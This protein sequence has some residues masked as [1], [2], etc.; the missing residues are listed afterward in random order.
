MAIYGYVTPAAERAASLRV[1]ALAAL[2][3]VANWSQIWGNHS[4]FAQF[5]PPSPLRHVWSHAVEEQWYLFWPPVLLGLLT[6]FRRRL[7]PVLAVVVVLMLGSALWMSHLVRAFADPSRAYYGTDTRAQ[8]LLAGAAL[9]LVL[10]RWP[11]T[12]ATLKRLLAVAGLI[13]FALCVAAM[14]HYS[15]TAARLYHG[16][17]LV[18]SLLTAVAV[19][20]LA[21]DTHSPLSRLLSIRPL[22]WIGR[23]SYGLYLW[24][25]L[26]DVWLNADRLSWGVAPLRGPHRHHLRHRDGAVLPG[27]AAHPERPVEPPPTAPPGH[28]RRPGVGRRARGAALLGHRAGARPGRRRPGGEPTGAPRPA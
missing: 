16:G 9:A 17:F 2:A 10:T 23:I 13:A 5:G 19:A 26:I 24:H 8:S 7:E 27:R 22:P 12:G 25:W 3:Y 18:F 15:G 20:T 4:Y 21:V 11:I 1:D 6:V 14:V 28:G